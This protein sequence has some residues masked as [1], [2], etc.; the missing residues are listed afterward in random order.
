MLPSFQILYY[1]LFDLDNCV[2]KILKSNKKFNS[3][4]DKERNV[5]IERFKLLR[6]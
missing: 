1:Y 2:I 3:L 5:L 6:D 4:N